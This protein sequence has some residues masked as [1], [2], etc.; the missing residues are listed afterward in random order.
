MKKE[1]IYK[2]NYNSLE[3]YYQE[4]GDEYLN[5]LETLCKD[6]EEIRDFLEKSIKYNIYLFKKK[7]NSNWTNKSIKQLMNECKNKKKTL[8]RKHADK[9]VDLSKSDLEDTIDKLD[10]ETKN[11]AYHL[12]NLDDMS[13]TVENNSNTKIYNE[14]SSIF[15]DNYSKSNIEIINLNLGFIAQ[16]E[17]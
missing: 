17:N 1:N 13:K 2:V 12:N 10:K 14:V 9:I 4:I 7:K 3:I 11:L 6:S 15:D 8:L 5:K 16:Y